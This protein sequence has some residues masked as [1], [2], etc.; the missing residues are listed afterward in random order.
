MKRAPGFSDAEDEASKTL[1]KSTPTSLAHIELHPLLGGTGSVDGELSAQTGRLQLLSTSSTSEHIGGRAQVTNP[2]LIQ[3][4]RGE[5]AKR[6]PSL[7]RFNR[8]GKFVARAEA[9][10]TAAAVRQLE[11]EIEDAAAELGPAVVDL[12]LAEQHLEEH[13]ADD[14]SDTEPGTE[15]EWWD[16]PYAEGNLD[17]LGNLVQRPSLRLD[18]RTA[19]AVSES[20][21]PLNVYLTV[22]ERKK[23]RRQRRLEAQREL[24]EQVALGLRAPEPPRLRLASLPRMLAQP[25]N[26]TAAASALGPTSVEAEARRQAQERAAEHARANA[27]RAAEAEQRRLHKRQQAASNPQDAPMNTC[28]V[29]V[30][31]VPG[32]KVL[33]EASA[34]FKVRVNAE[35]LGLRGRAVGSPSFTLIVV[36]AEEGNGTKAVQRYVRLL[37]VRMQSQLPGAALLWEGKGEGTRFP[38]PGDFVVVDRSVSDLDARE[39]ATSLGWLHYW[40]LARGAASV[41]DS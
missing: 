26:A 12:G 3:S 13:E 36:E 15:M 38:D 6:R 10:R 25:G 2:Y 35:Q 39:Y 14:A 28:H 4:R 40:K 24:Q 21:T 30:F 37:L 8:P 19:R 32:R 27:E 41:A 33:E 18:A 7:L 11:R 34:R 22:S 29:A 31:L 16:V 5:G 20:A 23:L 1:K 17:I 9:A